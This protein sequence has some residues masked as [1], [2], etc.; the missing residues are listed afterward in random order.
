MDIQELCDR[1]FTDDR[2]MQEVEV[3]EGGVLI[4]AYDKDL[5]LRQKE[6][7]EHSM[8]NYNNVDNNFYV[9]MGEN[10]L[11]SCYLEDMEDRV[12][13]YNLSTVAIPQNKVTNTN[14]VFC[15]KDF[16]GKKV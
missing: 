3:E 14:I 12:E 7:R 16:F 2:Y 13:V 10:S 11:S 6:Q 9:G 1:S 15:F 8:W 4:T 5:H